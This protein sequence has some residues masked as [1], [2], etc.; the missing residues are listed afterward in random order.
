MSEQNPFTAAQ[1]ATMEKFI[2]NAISASVASAITNAMAAAN[3]GGAPKEAP[4]QV[5]PTQVAPQQVKASEIGYF[6]P[7]MPRDKEWGDSD[8]VDKDGKNYY[9]DVYAFTNRL[10]V[11]A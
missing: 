11:A 8:L 2:Q 3:T 10:R 5:A 1:M 4:S 7:N 6:Y 9:R